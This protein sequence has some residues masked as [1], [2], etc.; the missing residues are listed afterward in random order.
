MK[1]LLHQ[2]KLLTTLLKLLKHLKSKVVQLKALFLQKKKSLLLQHCQTAK[3][4]FLC[5]FLYFKRQFATLH[6]L[7]KQLQK[8]KKTLRK[9]SSDSLVLS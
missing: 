6:L 7:S 5:S 8:A 4:F 3:D 2:L 1:M 9:Q